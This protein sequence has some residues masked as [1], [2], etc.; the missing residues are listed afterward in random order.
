[1]VAHWCL[2]K[3]QQLPRGPSSKGLSCDQPAE[4]LL[5]GDAGMATGHFYF[6]GGGGGQADRK[7]SWGSRVAELRTST[8]PPPP[9][10]AP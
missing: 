2:L 3:Q 6:T 8:R 1:M 10:P 5:T 9:R 7:P 4:V